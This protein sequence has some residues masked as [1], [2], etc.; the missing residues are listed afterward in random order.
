M[1]LGSFIFEES[2]LDSLAQAS[3]IG[4]GVILYLALIMTVLGL[5]DLVSCPFPQSSLKGYA[6]NAPASCLHDCHKY[7][8]S[9][10]TTLDHDFRRCS[11]SYWWSLYDRDN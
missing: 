6:C 7:G 9:W 11:R 2:Q 1:I 5:R 10:R 3:W 4:W 8:F